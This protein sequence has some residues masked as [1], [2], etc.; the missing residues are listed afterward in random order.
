MTEHPVGPTLS[1]RMLALELTAL[2]TAAGLDTTDV[3]RRLRL[4]R[5]QISHYEASRRLPSFPALV[6]LLEIYGAKN[7]L[8]EL[9][10]LLERADARGWWDVP[11]LSQETKTYLGLEADASLVRSFAQELVPGMLQH[12]SY[13]REI[14]LVHGATGGQDLDDAVITRVRRQ[15]RVGAGLTVDVVLSE[16]LLWRT[17]NMG[18]AGAD[19]LR[20]LRRAPDVPGISVRV[21]G[22][23][24]G[25]HRSM[26]G[27]FTLLDFPA[28]LA[29]PVGYM[30]N[31]LGARIAD[32]P[33]VVS[34]LDERYSE[35]VERAHSVQDS[36][37]M[38]AVLNRV[39]EA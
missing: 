33:Q 13:I 36:A 28:G 14:Q 1:G 2:R 19:Q 3:A 29:P 27:G 37:V 32:D 17:L 31:V 25:A 6:M 15:E 30:P 16:G 23:D 10:E 39:E 7:R 8:T 18:L 22:C 4:H 35:L 26:A 12:P 34:K 5:T 9:S 20:Y 38:A 24:V 21:L 11:G